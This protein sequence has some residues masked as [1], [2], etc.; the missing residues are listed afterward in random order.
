ML[1]SKTSI[2]LRV[3][4]AVVAVVAVGRAI[5]FTRAIFGCGTRDERSMIQW[6]R[7]DPFFAAVPPDGSLAEETTQAGSCDPHLHGDGG[8]GITLVSRRYQTP[9]GYSFDQLRHLG[10]QPAVAGGWS[11]EEGHPADP[12]TFRPA[13]VT[14]CKQI[15]LHVFFAVAQSPPVDF[16]GSGV[17][18]EIL[19]YPDNNSPTRPGCGQLGNPP[20]PDP[21]P[22]CPPTVSCLIRPPAGTPST[23]P[24][25]GYDT[26]WYYLDY[27]NDNSHSAINL[28]LDNNSTWFCGWGSSMTVDT[29]WTSTYTD[30][31]YGF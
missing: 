14:Y 13:A 31:N 12:S 10:D 16:T 4:V 21:D 7:A 26:N 25:G 9:A 11:L 29:K 30:I 18:V 23:R 27:T 20:A 6:F 8:V 2:I 22:S 15:G 5:V 1:I 24:I 28:C 3:V 19:H 17:L